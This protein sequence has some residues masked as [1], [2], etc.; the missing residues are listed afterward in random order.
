MKPWC[1]RMETHV[2]VNSDPGYRGVAL[3]VRAPR[4]GVGGGRVTGPG[5]LAPGSAEEVEVRNVGAVRAKAGH[6]FPVNGRQFGHTKARYREPAMRG[7]HLVTLFAP[8]I[9]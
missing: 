5:A 9:H 1:F 8:Q 3:L 6:P 4:R 7:S 2:D